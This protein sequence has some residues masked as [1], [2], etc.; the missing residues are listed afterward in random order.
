MSC[1]DWACIRA[2]PSATLNTPGGIV[3]SSI[4]DYSPVIPG[5]CS[6]VMPMN[7][8]REDFGMA[9]PA[10]R[11][12]YMGYKRKRDDIV[13]ESERE[14]VELARP[15]GVTEN[16]NFWQAGMSPGD[17]FYRRIQPSLPVDMVPSP[18]SAMDNLDVLLTRRRT[19]RSPRGQQGARRRQL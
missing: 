19:F 10:Y 7:Q 14:M 6:P 9:G 16:R 11:D 2:M 17:C 12:V 3:Y 1:P 13:Q 18:P 4:S 15:A 8:E 5:L